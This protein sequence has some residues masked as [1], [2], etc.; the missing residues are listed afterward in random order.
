LGKLSWVS[1]SQQCAS[2]TKQH[3]SALTKASDA[4]WL[5]RWPWAWRKV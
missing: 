5:R 3:N 4:L 2:V 1:Y